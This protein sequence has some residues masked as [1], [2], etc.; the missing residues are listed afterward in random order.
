M[1]DSPERNREQQEAGA[2]SSPGQSLTTRAEPHAFAG[3][4]SEDT[5]I[6]TG[7]DRLAGVKLRAQR[8]PWDSGNA[9]G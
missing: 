3:N 9:D 2:L 1:C 6:P 4:G 7:A 8:T 5:D